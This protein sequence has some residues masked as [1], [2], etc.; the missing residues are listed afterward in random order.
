MKREEQQLFVSSKYK[1]NNKY[2]ITSYD[3]CYCWFFL[4]FIILLAIDNNK[5]TYIVCTYIRIHPA[6]LRLT[7]L[8][9]LLEKYR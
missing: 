8:K 4:L 1:S 6:A 9:F 7:E 3:C 5:Q 2:K